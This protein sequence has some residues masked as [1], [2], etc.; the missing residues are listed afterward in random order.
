MQWGIN[1]KWGFDN[2][3]LSK[4]S[5]KQAEFLVLSKDLSTIDRLVLNFEKL[6]SDSKRLCAITP[7]DKLCI[8]LH[9]NR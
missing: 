3:F 7:L 2:H 1:F 5:F 8:R 6:V 4:V 9:L